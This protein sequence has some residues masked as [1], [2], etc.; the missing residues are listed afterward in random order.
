VE[1]QVYELA[2]DRPFTMAELAAEVS[3]QTGK[4]ITYRDLPPE[5]YRA[6]LTA[7]GLPGPV[8]DIYVDADVQAAKGELDDATGELRR[9]IGRPTTPLA[10]AVRT[11]LGR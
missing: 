2:G 10:A 11:A 3:R 6:V 1:K 4:P 8:A 9:L 5:Q 7:A